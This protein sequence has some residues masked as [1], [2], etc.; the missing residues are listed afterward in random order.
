VLREKLADSSLAMKETYG[1]ERRR[2]TAS[3][4]WIVARVPYSNAGLGGGG[5][6]KTTGNSMSGNNG[7][8]RALALC[9]ISMAAVTW[10]S[11][12]ARAQSYQLP[13][14]PGFGLMPPED[15]DPLVR[16]LGLTPIA[17]PRAHGPV[18]LIEAMGQEGS[19][20]R[21]TVDRRSG[22]VRQIVRLVPP[23]IGT[24]E[25]RPTY[26]PDDDERGV[27]RN[28]APPPPPYVQGQPGAYSG[29]QVI[30]REEIESEDLPPP[31][32]SPRIATREPDSTGAVPRTM[33]R[34]PVDPLLGVP[35]EF[36]NRGVRNEPAPAE[37]RK[38]RLAARTPADSV[39]RVAPL[40][41]PRPAD[42]PAIVLRES[43]P[44]MT[45]APKPP[46]PEAQAE[47]EQSPGRFPVQ[48]LE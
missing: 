20:V 23:Q 27:L 19:Q 30:T 48:P 37:P 24:I 22:R 39:P 33:S 7:R 35:A 45:E 38:E 34:G 5:E 1:G 8:L 25:Q 28:V 32:S 10:S 36:R 18:I 2:A 16:S 29:P 17:P 15:A 14:P 11:A 26:E 47:G 41:R 6:G 46:A 4:S 3:P 44:T 43:A 9:A 21:V 40:P 42:A 31:G 12:P 13:A